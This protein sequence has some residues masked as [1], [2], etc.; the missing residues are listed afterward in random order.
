MITS[1]KQ[2]QSKQKQ[3]K[4]PV[5]ELKT[6]QVVKNPV[7][8]NL[9][10]PAQPKTVMSTIG[11]VQGEDDE[12]ESEEESEVEPSRRPPLNQDDSSSEEEKV[13]AIVSKQKKQSSEK[14]SSSE[15]ED[16][17]ED[18]YASDKESLQLQRSKKQES[19]VVLVKQEDKFPTIESNSMPLH[20]ALRDP[21]HD[22]LVLI[23]DT[24]GDE[25]ENLQRHIDDLRT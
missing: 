8:A 18:F 9:P 13:K 6:S 15:E 11:Q 1:V 4:K 16:E 10:P 25:N 20:V 24:L 7:Q 19:Q 14:D 5:E 17:D 21:E 22:Q 2:Q 23:L 3:L 12:D